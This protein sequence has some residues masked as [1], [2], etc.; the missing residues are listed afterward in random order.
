M[1]KDIAKLMSFIAGFADTTGF[2]AL[3]GL[4]LAHVTGNFVTL[5]AAVSQG[6]SGMIGKLLALPIFCITLLAT[7]FLGNVYEREGRSAFMPLFAF[8][9]LL[10]TFGAFLALYHGPFIGAD[11]SPLLIV[12]MLWVMAMAIQNGIHRIHMKGCPPTTVVTGSTTQIMLDFTDLLMGKQSNIQATK[13]QLKGLL[14]SVFFFALGC[15]S[16]AVSYSFVSIW[17]FVVPPVLSVITLYLLR[18]NPLHNSD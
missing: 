6:A 10:L 16:A 5:G 2:V 18:R 7:R 12:G 3:H 8:E 4:F 14:S 13:Q 1:N 17:C 11:E 15:A 9:A